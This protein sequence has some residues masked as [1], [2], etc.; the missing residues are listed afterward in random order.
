MNSSLALHHSPFAVI[1]SM[2]RSQ[3]DSQLGGSTKSCRSI[4]SQRL[5]T[6]RVDS[7]VYGAIHHAENQTAI[8]D[9]LPSWLC[10]RCHFGNGII[11][12]TGKKPATSACCVRLLVA[13]LGTMGLHWQ[14]TTINV[15]G[16]Q[17][18]LT[19]LM[20]FRLCYFMS[21]LMS[22]IRDLHSWP[23]SDWLDSNECSDVASV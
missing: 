17:P 9:L 3:Q 16:A 1:N 20:L 22:T 10:Y 4:L 5:L 8:H 15:F 18:I 13:L 12:M 7:T 23:R 19:I 2:A 14:L 21:W 11:C 6:Y